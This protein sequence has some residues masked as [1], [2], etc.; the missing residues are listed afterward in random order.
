MKQKMF[1]PFRHSLVGYLGQFEA[2]L[3]FGFGLMGH[4]GK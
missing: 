1:H 4:H 3:V 2:V